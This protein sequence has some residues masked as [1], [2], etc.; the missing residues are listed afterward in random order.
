MPC[1]E[2]ADLSVIELYRQCVTWKKLPKEGGIL[3]QDARIMEAFGVIGAEV[4]RHR[5][6]REE[7]AE[8]NLRREAER[9]S[10]R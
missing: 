3:S 10:R 6:M 5:R 7:E 4:E 8:R 1:V 9:A 2:S